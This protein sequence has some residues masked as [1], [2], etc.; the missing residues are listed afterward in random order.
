MMEV[1]DPHSPSS[2]Y[3]LASADV[4]KRLFDAR[5][6]V[7]L[8]EHDLFL[9]RERLEAA[10]LRHEKAQNEALWSHQEEQAAIV[11]RVARLAVQQAD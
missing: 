1:R 5:D 7:E 3:E 9:I 2:F 11:D 4:R 10:V 6:V 8:L